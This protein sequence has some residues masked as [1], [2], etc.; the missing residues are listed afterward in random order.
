MLHLYT[1][2]SCW[3]ALRLLG[4]L[5]SHVGIPR[6]RFLSALW[7]KQM[8]GYGIMIVWDASQF[9][10]LTGWLLKLSAGEWTTLRVEQ[11]LLIL[12]K[13]R[14]PGRSFGGLGCRPSLRSLHGAWLVPPYLRV[15][16]GLD[17]IFW[18]AQSVQYFKGLKIH[19]DMLCLSVICGPCLGN[20]IWWFEPPSPWRWHNRSKTVALLREQNSE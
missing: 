19:G 14:W 20:A 6:C 4:L 12:N 8:N 3:D 11:N 18:I 10:R 7:D 2:S 1:E 13:R 17:D 16:S 5:C 9:G 15:Q